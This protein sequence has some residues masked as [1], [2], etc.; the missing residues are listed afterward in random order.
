L[1]HQKHS[2]SG[3]NKLAA[4]KHI[5]IGPY[6]SGKQPVVTKSSKTASS[7]NNQ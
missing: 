3:N 2:K 7:D 6:A 1:Q 4:T 5:A